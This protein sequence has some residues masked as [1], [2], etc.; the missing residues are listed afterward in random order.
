MIQLAE[1]HHG[2]A[3]LIVA[4]QVAPGSLTA[5]TLLAGVEPILDASAGQSLFS[6][7]WNLGGQ[8]GGGGGDAG[9]G[10]Q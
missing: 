10:Q 5:C 8:G 3:V 9:G 4:T 1:L 2:D 6:A 7:S